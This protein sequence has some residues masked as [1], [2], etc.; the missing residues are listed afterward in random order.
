MVWI[1]A[2]EIKMDRGWVVLYKDD[3]VICEDEMSWNKLP[4]KKDIKRVILK[5]E[6]RMWSLDD[7]EHYTV[8][9]TRGYMDV[10]STGIA[11]QGIDSR[12]IGYYDVEASCKVFYR[13]DENTGKMNIETEPF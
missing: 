3:A 6:D 13:V 8:P 9:K 2:H 5:W 12:A 7:K 10:N 1:G 4:N 11:G